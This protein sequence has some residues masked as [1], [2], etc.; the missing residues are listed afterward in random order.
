MDLFSRKIDYLRISITDRCN[1]RCL[2]CMPEGYHG[3]AQKSDHLTATEI[4]R[5]VEAAVHLGFRKFRLTGGEPLIRRDVV[6]IVRSMAALSGVECLGLSTNGTALT[7]LAEPLRK[8]GLRTI[9]ISLDTLNP[10]RYHQ[11]TGSHLAPVLAGIRAAKAAEF[12]YIKLNCVLL[13]GINDSDL[14]PLVLFAAE[15]GLPLRLIE[16]MPLSNTEVLKDSN[17]LSISEAMERLQEKDELIP[18][19]DRRL[20]WG[21]AKYYR[22]KRVGAMVGFIGALTDQHFCETCNKIRLTA[23]G[24]IRPC[25][26]QHEEI[27]LRGALRTPSDHQTVQSLLLDA[28]RRKPQEHQF[29][30]K[31]QPQRPMTSIGG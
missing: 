3:W 24:K 20:G 26:G 5:V 15:Y 27:D 23:D 13:R 9:N 29:C 28:I 6:A 2:Y 14:W 7:G 10:D 16:L 8:A 31:Y 17:F 11:V 21:P 22:L 25:L 12:E 1:E 19:P 30:G 4:L 18:C